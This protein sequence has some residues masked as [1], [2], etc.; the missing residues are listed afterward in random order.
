MKPRLLA[1][2]LS[3]ALCSLASSAASATPPPTKADITKLVAEAADYQPGQSREPLARIEELMRQP[4]ASARNRLETGLVQLLGPGSTFEARRFA[5]K[6]LG[7]IGSRTALPALSGLLTNDETAGIACLALTTYPPGKADEIL[8]AALPSAHGTA[9]IQI[10]TTLGDRRDSRAVKL[11][12]QSAVD[13]DLSVAKAAIAALGKIGDPAARKAIAAL[14]QNA[15]PTLQPVLTEATLRCA[16]ARAASGDAKAA[17]VI[18]E[19]QLAATH[20]VYVRRGALDALLRLD[21]AHAQQRILQVLHGSDSALKPVAI[22]N[23]RALPT[24]NASEVFAAEL[25]NLTPQ[26]QVWMIDSLAARGDAPACTA[27]GN[28]LS[29]PDAAVRRAGIVS[30]GRIGDAW[31]VPL[32]ARTLDRSNDAEERRAV[33]SALISLP[34]GAQTDLA[35]AAA[36]KQSS[37][38]TRANLITALARRQGPAANRLLLAE[39]S[40]SDPVVAKAAFRALAKTAGGWE[41]TPLLEKL[42]SARDEA[43]RSEAANAVAQA[44]SRIDNPGRRSALVRDALRWAQSVDSRITLLGLLPECA[45]AAALI[46]LKATAAEPDFRLRDAAVAALAEW[47]D[48]SAWDALA[49]IYRRPAAETVR[50]LALRGLVRLAGEENAH[51]SPKLVEHYRLLLEGAHG[52]ADLRLILGA[53]GGAAQPGALELALPLLANTAVRPEA[54]VAVKKIAEAIKAQHPKAAQEALDRLQG[55]P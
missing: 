33:E 37:G 53:L 36:L 30:L 24:T 19:E 22:A 2:L 5:C 48:T 44:L 42:T 31:C 43:I 18:Y 40:Q 17:G 47:P 38:N 55:K 10:I 39:A 15:D 14:P 6:E 54:E 9:R 21:K 4:S 12:A 8:R 3:L 41:V 16:E 27:I 25:P 52:E 26:E 49:D 51:P 46:T 7:I 13:A 34:G 35:I 32:F 28:S 1:L 29:S 23:V 45:D 50:S 11:L 20:P